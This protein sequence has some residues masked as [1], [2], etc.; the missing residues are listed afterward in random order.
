VEEKDG[1]DDDDNARRERVRNEIKKEER[2][3]W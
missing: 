3:E 2:G 1:G